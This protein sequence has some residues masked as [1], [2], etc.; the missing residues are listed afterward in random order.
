MTAHFARP[1]RSESVDY[2]FTYIDQVPDGDIVATLDR[3]PGEARAVFEGI[4]EERSLHRY[5]PGKWTIRE[6]LSH[7]NDT[8]RIFAL[9]ALWFARSLGAPLPGF[10]QDEAIATAGADARS[11]QSHMEEFTAIRAATVALFRNLPD[12]AWARQ[13][14]ASGNTFSVNALAWI[15]AGHVAHHLKLLRDRY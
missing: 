11:W 9:R 13:G 5:A 4:D 2:Y 15:T 14:V 6:L 12:D 7:V 1:T 10:E 3:Q 8:E